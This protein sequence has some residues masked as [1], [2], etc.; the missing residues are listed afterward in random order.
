MPDCQSQY[1][2][3]YEQ[4]ILSNQDMLHAAKHKANIYGEPAIQKSS[5]QPKESQALDVQLKLM[6]SLL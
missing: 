4:G 5:N 1:I 3:S 6:S 2:S